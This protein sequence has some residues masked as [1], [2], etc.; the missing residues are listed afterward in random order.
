M[1]RH[2]WKI[3]FWLNHTGPWITHGWGGERQCDWGLKLGK[4]TNSFFPPAECT[5]CF[6]MTTQHNKGNSRCISSLPVSML[7]FNLSIFPPRPTFPPTLHV[8]C[9][10]SA[11]RVMLEMLRRQRCG[12]WVLTVGMVKRIWNAVTRSWEEKQKAARTSTTFLKTSTVVLHPKVGEKK[13]N[14][15]SNP[16]DRDFIKR[17]RTGG[18]QS[19]LLLLSAA[20]STLGRV[21]GCHHYGK[22][23]S[24]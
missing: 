14:S 9:E 23:K 19:A 15:A 11:A 22:A 7:I 18:V 3:V 8:M 24:I 2:T 6:V 10:S 21:C 4:R 5:H 20:V 12:V 13:R 17:N 1:K 16:V